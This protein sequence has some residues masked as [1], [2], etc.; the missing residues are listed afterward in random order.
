M[1]RPSLLMC[2][3]DY[4]EIAYEI[5][6]W[7]SVERK[8]DKKEAAR[9]WKAYYELLTGTLKAKV[10]LLEPAP[11]LPDLVF[12]ANGGIVR[13][14]IFVRGNFRYKERKGEEDIFSSWFRKK[15]YIVRIVEPPFCFEGEGDALQMGEELY[16]GFHFRSDVE[17]HD[18]VSGFLKM[19]YF[20]LELTDKRFYHL[21][22]C[23]MPLDEKSALVFLSAF[24]TYAQLVLIENIPDLIRVPEEEAL[25]FACNAVVL[26]KDVI[27]PEGCPQTVKELE[28][29][30][31]HVYSLA[32]GEFIKAGGA[33]KCLVL[34]I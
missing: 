26:G 6:P 30:G 34:K 25:R 23:F 22:T 12:T 18:A 13:K 9:Q 16:T 33:A 17:A 24:E 3:P 19:S 27:L 28:S 1:D 14:R 11:K 7:M 29:R 5:N 21:D 2:P 4:Y 31:F 32:F 20:A 10:E 15:G 8:A